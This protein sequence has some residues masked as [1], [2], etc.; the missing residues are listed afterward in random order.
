MQSLVK[1]HVVEVGIGDE[2]LAVHEAVVDRGRMVMDKVC[3]GG[4]GWWR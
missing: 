1:I 2:R 3:G 4:L